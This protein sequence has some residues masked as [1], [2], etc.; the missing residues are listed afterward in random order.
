MPIASQNRFPKPDFESGYQYPDLQ[1]S[2]PNEALWSAVDIFLLVAMM[3]VVAWATLKRR[4]RA[5]MLII[6]VVSVLY[7]GFFRSG[8]VC[9]IGSVQ[10]VTLAFVD[11]SYTLPIVV[12]LFFI[13]PVVFTFL[14]GRVFC[15]GVCPLGALQEIVNIRNYR[16]SRSISA[17]LGVIPWAYLSFALLYAAT[18]SS[19]IVCRFDPFVG[20]FRMGGDMGMIA[21]GGLLLLAAVFTGRPFCRFLC[22]YGALLSLFSRVSVRNMSITKEC[23][24]CDLCLNACPV[25]AIRPP[26]ENKVKESRM[27][28]VRRLLAYFVLLPVAAA[29]GAFGMNAISPLLAGANKDVRLY[30]QVMRN[31]VNP[32]NIQPVDVEVFFA[33][34][35]TIE[36]LSARTAEIRRQFRTYS[37]IAGGAIGLVVG[38]TLIG[39]SVKRTRKTYEIDRAA[40][41]NCGRCFAYCPQNKLSIIQ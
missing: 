17:V 11:A 10:N 13:L 36:E 15:S 3:G 12:F 23:I 6:S 14:F 20:I 32:Q 26:F 28:G 19:F 9:S 34:G 16:L 21:F 37:G 29:A 24:N 22:P 41:I 38:L 18:R 1:Y 31:E 25:D 39:L 27:D 5:P 40:C 7:F 8:C 35:G 2:A 4:K 33:Q 30:E